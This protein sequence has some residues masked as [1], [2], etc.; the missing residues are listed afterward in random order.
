ITNESSCFNE[1]GGAPRCIL[2][3]QSGT[4]TVAVQYSVDDNGFCSNDTASGEGRG[5]RP[6][7][8]VVVHGAYRKDRGAYGINTCASMDYYIKEAY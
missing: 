2:T 3:V 6:G 7:Q 1:T 8:G 5:M 4:K